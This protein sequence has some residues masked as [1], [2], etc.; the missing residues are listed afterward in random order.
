LN[1]DLLDQEIRKMTDHHTFDLF[2]LGVPDH[3]VV[4]FPVSR[5]VVDV[6][7]YE[8][9]EEE[10]MSSMGM[11]VVY[12]VT[13]DRRPLR[14]TL[15]ASEREEL[16]SRWYRPHHQALSK[17]V[18]RTIEN[19]GQALIIDAHSF[20]SN[21]L[22]Y[23]NDPAALRPEICIGTDSFH[24]PHKIVESLLTEFESLGFASAVNTPFSGALVPAKHYQ[25]DARV[26]AVMIEVRRDLYLDEYSGQLDKKSSEV[27]EKLRTA[28]LNSLA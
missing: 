9:D 15:K 1:D 28:L 11:G 23:E 8:Q 7:R 27:S 6:E 2:A 12:Q 10:P 3:Q 22:P 25:R 21:A 16:L 14:R 26:K 4:R 5:L 13:H 18:D 20:P 24:T 19:F 17:A